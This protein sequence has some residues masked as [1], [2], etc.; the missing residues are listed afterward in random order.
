MAESVC[1]KKTKK[2]LHRPD[3]GGTPWT[4]DGKVAFRKDRRI[5]KHIAALLV[6]RGASLVILLAFTAIFVIRLREGVWPAAGWLIVGLGISSILALAA[7]ITVR[8]LNKRR[9]SPGPG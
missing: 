9:F 3:A 2:R 5:A 8:R 1:I 6:L 4:A 7:S